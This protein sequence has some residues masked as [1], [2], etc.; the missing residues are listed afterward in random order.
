MI[1]FKHMNTKKI[2]NFI[3]EPNQLKRQAHNGFQHAGVKYPDT[4]AEHSLRAAQIGYILASMEGVNPEKVATMLVIHDNA[5]TRI[6]DQN[7]LAA[8]YYSNKEAEHKAFE[9][10]LQNLNSEIA[11]KWKK[12][13]NEYEKRNTKKGIVARDADWLETAF[14]AK[15]YFDLGYKAAMDWISNVERALETKSAKEIL[16]EMKKTE[17]TDWW[18]GLKKMTYKK[19]EK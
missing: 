19:L 14:Q 11:A 17:F 16:K 9:E 13:F 10:Q 6:G 5:E 1:K 2:V 18:Q 7:K 8:R 4:I 3:F 12:Y 15:E